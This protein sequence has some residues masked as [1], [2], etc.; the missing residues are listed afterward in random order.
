M[1]TIDRI[2][3]KGFGPHRISIASI[4]LLPLGSDGLLRTKCTTTD[5]L[6]S[7]RAPGSSLDDQTKC[8][9]DHMSFCH[10]CASFHRVSHGKIVTL[11]NRHAFTVRNLKRFA[12]AKLESATLFAAMIIKFVDCF[13][14]LLPASNYVCVL[15]IF[16]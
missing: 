14:S 12:S 16:V 15:C 8:K 9:C 6:S 5:Q 4:S 13:Q 2:L 11:Y 3:C 1:Q 10:F 7:L